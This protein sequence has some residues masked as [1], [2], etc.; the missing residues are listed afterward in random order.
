MATPFNAAEKVDLASFSRSLQFMERAGVSGVTIVGVLGESNR[1]LDDERRAMIRC[2]REA[3]KVP[4]CVGASH[5]GTKATIGLMEMAAEEKADAVMVTP[6]KEPVPSDVKV[7]EYF[8]RIA[9]AVPTMP[10]VLQDHP[11]STLVHMPLELVAKLANEI[12]SVACIKLES[13]PSPPRIA[14]LKPQLPE[15]CTILTGLGALYG[16]FDI[17]AGSDGFMTGFAFPEVL[18]AMVKHYPKDPELAFQ[19]YQRFLPLM[20]YEQTPGVAVRKELYRLR[21]LLDEPVVRHPGGGIS[22][23]AAAQ[24]KG[25]VDSLGDV[26]NPID[27][28]K[29]L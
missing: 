26:T 14:A 24:L 22:P 12:P 1:L 7:A 11:A 29:L 28:L 27:V 4:I 6:S 3:V 13:L 10:L 18:L 25:L 20:V 5:A 15:R 23:M 19:I 8:K 17:A 21:G 2:A 9:A 16:H